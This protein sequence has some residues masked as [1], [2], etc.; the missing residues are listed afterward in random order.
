MSAPI[1]AEDTKPIVAHIDGK[2]VDANGRPIANAVVLGGRSLSMMFAGSITTQA[3]VYTG[4]DGKFSLPV[5][6]SDDVLLMAAHHEHGMSV[7]AEESSAGADVELRLEPFG[8][9]V[10]SVKEGSEPVPARVILLSDD[11]DKARFAAKTEEDGSYRIGPVP[12]GDYTVGASTMMR[13][14][15]NLTRFPETGASIV[16]GRSV[17]HDVV[18]LDESMIVLESTL[19]EELDIKWVTLAAFEGEFEASE[20]KFDRKDPFPGKDATAGWVLRGGKDSHDGDVSFQGLEPGTYTA[21][22]AVTPNEG[23]DTVDCKVIELGEK[24]MEVVE[25]HP[26]VPEDETALQR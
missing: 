14:P 5:Y 15:G 11:H 17:E 3:G 7:I 26:V 19:P 9:L 22:I 20:V 6:Q 12:P 21:C 25:L 8:W 18:A 4:D 16:P 10:G 23:E 13:D 2:V 24:A 1:S